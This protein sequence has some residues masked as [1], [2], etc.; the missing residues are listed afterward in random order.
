MQ[1]ALVLII[2]SL[3]VMIICLILILPEIYREDWYIDEPELPT[4]KDKIIEWSFKASLLVTIIGLYIIALDSYLK[5][6]YLMTALMLL[7]PVWIFWDSLKNKIMSR[8]KK[9]DLK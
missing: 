9:K 5:G 6:F 8:M 2:P 7:A 1:F 4:T 3:S